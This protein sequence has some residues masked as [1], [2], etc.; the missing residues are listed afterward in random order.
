ML[1]GA[2]Y[3]RL[4]EFFLH[5]SD[6]RKLA[7]RERFVGLLLDHLKI[8]PSAYGRIPFETGWLPA[9]RLTPAQPKGTFVVFGGYD[10]YICLLYTSRCV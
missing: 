4:A 5:F 3:L 9:Y 10:S 6:P 2:Y 8:A 7:T 1:K